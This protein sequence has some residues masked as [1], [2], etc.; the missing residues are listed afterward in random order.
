MIKAIKGDLNY[1]YNKSL[2]K[3]NDVPV[4]ISD[5]GNIIL[6][7]GNSRS[8]GI[9]NEWDRCVSMINPNNFTKSSINDGKFE[10]SG[11]RL[12]SDLGAATLKFNTLRS[13]GQGNKL[14]LELHDSKYDYIFH[15]DGESFKASGSHT[16]EINYDGQINV[17][18]YPHEK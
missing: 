16:I 6:L 3:I 14:Y 10:L 18:K 13:L 15:V 5:M 7:N 8:G 11:F 9:M 2:C 1:R 12:N 4:D 17:L